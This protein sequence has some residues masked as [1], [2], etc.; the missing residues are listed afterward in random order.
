MFQTLVD[1]LDL[2]INQVDTGH[3]FVISVVPYGLA[4]RAAGSQPQLRTNN[5]N[6]DVVL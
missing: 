5:G 6:H 4:P 2:K 3:M 1:L